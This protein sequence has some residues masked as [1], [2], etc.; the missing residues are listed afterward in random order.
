MPRDDDHRDIGMVAPDCLE[1][2]DTVHPAVLE[3][4]VKDQQ[5]RRPGANGRHRIVGIG[6]KPRVIALVAE[7]VRDHLANVALV[8]DDQNIAH[9]TLIRPQGP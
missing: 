4:D 3:P 5:A 8:I 2:V 9:T 7:N 6:G 1:D